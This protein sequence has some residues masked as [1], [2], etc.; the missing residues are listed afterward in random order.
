MELKQIFRGQE[1][2]ELSDIGISREIVGKEIDRLKK[3]K[4]PGPDDISPRILKECKEELSE[5]IAKIF[6]KSLYT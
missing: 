5:T 2:D 1:F 6:R 4:T 3:T